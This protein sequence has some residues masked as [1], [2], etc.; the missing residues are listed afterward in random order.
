LKNKKVCAVGVTD[1]AVECTTF[2]YSK[3]DNKQQDSFH[4]GQRFHSTKCRDTK[5][6]DV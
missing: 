5:L 6:E 2:Y 3:N 4:K 1:A